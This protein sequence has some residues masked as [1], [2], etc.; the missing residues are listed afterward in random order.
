MS[1]TDKL[2]DLLTKKSKVVAMLAPSFPIMYDPK[3][4]VSILKSIGFSYVVEVAVGAKKTNE[5][6]AA[7]LK[8]NPHTRFITS[9]CASFVRFMRTKHSDLLH[10]V[11]FEIDSPMVATA[12]I[13]KAKWPDYKPVFI[14][15]CVVKKL[16][17]LQ[18]HPELDILVLTY[19]ELEEV[20]KKVPKDEPLTEAKFDLEEASTRIYP[21]DGGLTDTSGARDLLKEEEIRVV[22]GYKNCEK[23]IDE[24]AKNNRIRLLDILF[25][26]GGCIIGP[27]ISSNLSLDQRKAKIHGYASGH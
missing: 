3:T 18:D 16:E 9:P 15:P 13:V 4:I 1:D 10:H 20:M 17:A 24:F 23:A 22:S 2:V 25:C 6:A 11:A 7:I 12:K 26:D 14:G 5:Q 27:G 8:N 21:V 19:R